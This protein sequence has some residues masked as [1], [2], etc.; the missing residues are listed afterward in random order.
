MTAQVGFYEAW[1]DLMRSWGHAVHE[2]AGWHTRDAEPRTTYLPGRLYVEHHDASTIRSGNWGALAYI[3][4]QKL[5]NIVTARDG[6]VMLTAAGVCWHAGQGGPRF[7]VARNGANPA[8][9][10]NEVANSGSEPYSAGCTRAVIDGE[11]AWAIVSGR[12]S[13]AELA[14][15]LGHYE[16]ATPPGR[17]ID[18]RVD[19]NARRRDV[20]LRVAAHYFP[21][22]PAPSP[23]TPTPGVATHAVV[24][25]ETLYGIARRY[26]V[27]VAQLRQWNGLAGDLLRPGQQLV[28]AA[29]PAGPPAP[30]PATDHLPAGSF[31]RPGQA[32]VGGE[33]V[34]SMQ[35]D[36][37]LVIYRG[38]RA[39]W[40]TRTAG[41]PGAFLSFQT[42]GNAVVY[43]GGGRPLWTTGTHGRGGN[44]L[45]MQRDGN[46]VIYRPDGRPVWARR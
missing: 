43:D 18:P 8:S 17:K 14:R 16:W 21:P 24:Q 40:S 39:E 28:V 5:A 7:D 38:G 12:T 35:G 45:V 22:A 6:Q 46:L 34:L 33:F 10:G 26:G 30:A 44:R 41:R 1:R 20:E 25:G 2:S 19:M 13:P 37:N 31:L 4:Q 29:V 36:G 27:T 32:L 11:A 15:I 23:G 3:V 9:M 42:D